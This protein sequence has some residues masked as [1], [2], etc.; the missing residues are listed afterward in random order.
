MTTFTTKNG[1][2]VLKHVTKG[3]FHTEHVELA[4]TPSDSQGW[5]VIKKFSCAEL[6][7]F[8]QQDAEVFA[9]NAEQ[10]LRVPAGKITKGDSV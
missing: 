2:V 1:T 6:S 3:A 7:D 10:K 4:Y 9:L 5:G 8:T